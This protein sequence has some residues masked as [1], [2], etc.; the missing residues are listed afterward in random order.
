MVVVCAATSQQYHYGG[1]LK[2]LSEPSGLNDV[3]PLGARNVGMCTTFT[4]ID[5]R[6]TPPTITGAPFALPF[7][8]VMA[9]P[10]GYRARYI[11]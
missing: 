6:Q 10:R 1:R 8:K 9:P 2:D 3:A 5:L 7:T 11:T 4:T